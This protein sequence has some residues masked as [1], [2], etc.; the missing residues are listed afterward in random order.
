MKR[1]VI[2]LVAMAATLAM[3]S[4]VCLAETAIQKCIKEKLAKMK[5]RKQVTSSKGGCDTGRT[6]WDGR[7]VDCD[8]TH[9]YEAPP[10]YVIEVDTIEIVDKEEAGSRFSI[11]G[12]SY[13]NLAAT[14]HPRKICAAYDA[15]SHSGS[16]A[17]PGKIKFSF[18]V[19]I[20]KPLSENSIIEATLSCAK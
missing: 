5:D 8:G 6:R 19:Y 12:V 20:F 2:V 1:L 17:G 13:H 14:G 11:G 15:W 10:G 4:E 9:C 7:R 16:N 3:A 18:R